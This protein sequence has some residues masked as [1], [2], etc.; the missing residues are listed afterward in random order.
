[1]SLQVGPPKPWEKI[2]LKYVDYLTRIILTVAVGIIAFTP[3]RS[4]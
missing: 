3:I 1:M 2:H 4:Y